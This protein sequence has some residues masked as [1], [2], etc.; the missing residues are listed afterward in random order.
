MV[1]TEVFYKEKTRK[2]NVILVRFD[3]AELQSRCYSHFSIDLRRHRLDLMRHIYTGGEAGG[4]GLDKE[5]VWSVECGA[6]GSCEPRPV[7]LVSLPDNMCV[8]PATAN[9]MSALPECPP[10]PLCHGMSFRYNI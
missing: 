2:Q 7:R 3:G 5:E 8:D 4:G 1:N 10:C 6:G 9:S